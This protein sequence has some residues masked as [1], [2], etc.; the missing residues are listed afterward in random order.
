MEIKHK[1]LP[2][3]ISDNKE[4]LDREQIYRWLATTYWAQKRPRETVFASLQQSLCFGLYGESGQAGFARVVT[5]YATFSWVC[6]VFIAPAHRGKGLGKWLM[7]TV[8]N[9]PAICRTNMTLVTRD[10]HGLYE[11]YGFVRMEMMRRMAN[12][13]TKSPAG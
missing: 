4:D 5:D 11:Q 6:D 10:A 2:Y 9:H 8:V 7:E 13:Q 12:E 1:C 3:S